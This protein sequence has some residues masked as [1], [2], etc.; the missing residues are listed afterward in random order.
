MNGQ[1]IRYLA[2]NGPSLIYSVAKD[3]ASRSETKIHY[4]TVNRRVHE[5]VQQ[6]YIQK[7]GTRVTKAGMQADL[8]VTTIRGDFA[9]LAGMPNSYGTENAAEIT[10]KEIRQII[11]SASLRKGSP[12]VLLAHI[13]EDGQDGIDFVEKEVMPEIIKGVKNGYLNLDALD[14]GV[15]CSAFA[16]LI[17]R[18]VITISSKDH[19]ANSKET[20]KDY[21]DMLMRSLEKTIDLKDPVIDKRKEP[22]KDNISRSSHSD[23]EK[24]SHSNHMHQQ[25]LHLA[26]VSRQWCSELKV[27]LRLHAVRLD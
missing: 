21:I 18:N 9:A 4:P 23:M 14:E 13:M 2:L 15:I 1:I 25:Q 26:S 3:L 17:A 5:L 7:A 11:A 24:N 27:F 6:E 19:S 10:P 12:F 22:E 20:H 16:S 8:Y